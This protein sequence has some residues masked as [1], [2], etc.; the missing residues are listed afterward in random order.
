MKNKKLIGRTS[1][2][3]EFIIWFLAISIIPLIIISS[4]VFNVS[5]ISLTELGE[6]QIKNSVEIIYQ[7]AEEYNNEVKEGN[8]YIDLAQE[9]LRQQLLGPK[10]DGKRSLINQSFIV[11]EDDFLLAYNSSGTMVMHPLLE[12]KNFSND[13]VVQQIIKQKEGFFEYTFT[14]SNGIS[15]DVILYLKYF[16]PWDWIIANNTFKDNFNPQVSE[17]ESLIY[18]LLVFIGVMIIVSALLITRKIVKPINELSNGMIYI[19]EGDFTHSVYVKSK[20]E[21]GLLAENMNKASSSIKLL[22]DEAKNSTNKVSQSSKILNSL[23]LGTNEMVNKVAV[24]IENMDNNLK[25]QGA[26]VDNLFSIM[27]E[28]AASYQEISAAT[29]EVKTTSSMAL[30]A[31]EKGMDI[32]KAISDQNTQ[33]VN[34]VNHSSEKINKLQQ[35]T[36]DIGDI[37][38]LI[39]EI[40]SQTNLLAINAAIEAA[41]AGVYGRGF[42]VVAEEIRNLA[43]DTSKAANN[44]RVKIEGI[45]QDTEQT[46]KKFGELIESVTK[47]SQLLEQTEEKFELIIES[48]GNVASQI[49]EVAITINEMATGTSNAVEDVSQVS[50]ISSSISKSSENLVVSSEEQVEISKEIKNSANALDIMADDLSKVINKFKI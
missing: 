47:E 28:L 45:Q 39:T 40:S 3:T 43:E 44:V 5:K 42:A 37:I 13:Q 2:K 49:S 48:V 38:D 17:I 12:G 25:V 4:I 7:M 30:K 41:R 29:E 36:L 24:L 50:N 20:N 18:A 27:E 46:F 9:K 19:G 32:I 8:N 16:E 35:S 33:I 21:L 22:I 6:E 26:N 23:A 31:G 11:G 10:I 34:Y 15:R 1:L 14:D